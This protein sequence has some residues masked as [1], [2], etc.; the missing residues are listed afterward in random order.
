VGS[1]K[2]GRLVMVVLLVQRYNCRPK[3]GETPP[4]PALL[5]YE[6]QYGLRRKGTNYSVLTRGIS[7]HLLLG[8]L[9]KLL[10]GQTG[11]VIVNTSTVSES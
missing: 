7:W 3:D 10:A 8:Y 11:R 5:F 4:D 9:V 2:L 6:S 1:I